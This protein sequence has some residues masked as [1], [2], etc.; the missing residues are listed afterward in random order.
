M[1]IGVNSRL[2]IEVGLGTKKPALGGLV[3]Y[4]F[5]LYSAKTQ[6]P[7]FILLETC[8]SRHG[9]YKFR[10]KRRFWAVNGDVSLFFP[11]LRMANLF[12]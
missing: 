11:K 4:V 2:A 10:S 6:I 5:S 3:V 1:G 9:D 12:M 8:L 7:E